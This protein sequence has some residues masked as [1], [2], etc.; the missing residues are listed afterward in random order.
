[1]NIELQKSIRNY[2]YSLPT[3][4]CLSVTLTMKQVVE[5]EYLDEEKSVKNFRHFLNRLNKRVYGNAHK[6]FK[7]SI[8][9]IPVLEK[10]FYGRFH[11]HLILEKPAHIHQNTYELMIK[12]C[13]KKTRFGYYEIDIR[14]IYSSGWIDYITKFASKEDEIDYE[15][16]HWN[17]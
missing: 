5:N 4:D 15:N 3:K 14:N 7:K 2:I 9:V 13:W 16:I 12:E 1:M 17:S 11:Y 6:R 10:P 8:S